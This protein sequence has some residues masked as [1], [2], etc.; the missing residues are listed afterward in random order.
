MDA[1]DIYLADLNDEVR[2]R[3]LVASTGQFTRFTGR[4]LVAP[5]V[6]RVEGE[7]LYPWRV[8]SGAGV[9]AV[10]LLRS[11]PAERLL[12]Q[13]GRATPPAIERVRRAIGHITS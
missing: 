7:V 12:E 9:F 8:D 2:R 4:V 11:L 5:E 13:T 6:P 3:V 10:D 1:G